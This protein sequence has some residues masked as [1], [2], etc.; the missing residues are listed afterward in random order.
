MR[1]AVFSDVHGNR[2]ALEAVLRAVRQEGDFDAIIAAGDLCLGGSQPGECVDLLREAGVQAVYGNTE[3]YLR[4]PDQV[5]NDEPHQKMWSIIEPVAR[6]ALEQ[7]ST[8]QKE[9]L[10]GLPFELRFRPDRQPQNELL[11]V[12]A[13][14]K[15]V[16]LMILPNEQQQSELW[17]E[18]RQPDDSPDLRRV[19]EAEPADT[20]AFG[21]VHYTFQRDWREKKLVGV[22]CCGL[23]G[24]D[25]DLRARFTIF[26]W[27]GSA[28]QIEPHWV[29]YDVS[30]EIAAL[31]ASG[32]PS[33]DHFLRY[34][35]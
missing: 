11:V 13:N 9:W 29:E 35:N 6:W 4:Y 27:D 22:A 32:M 34:Y 10:F 5:P 1:L 30:Q 21:H 26:K 15:D 2:Y 28:W 17:G 20:L 18:V 33:Q 3:L 7:L 25:H 23:P 19:L 24:I 14:P 8:E 12:H 31:K 16:E